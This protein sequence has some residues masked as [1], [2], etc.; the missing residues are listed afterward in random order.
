MITFNVLP[1]D[2]RTLL[3]R[4]SEPVDATALSIENYS[5]G[6]TSNLSTTLAPVIVSVTPEGNTG[7]DYSLSFDLPL[8]FL[9]TY[10][11]SVQDVFGED[12]SADGTENFTSS[13]PDYPRPIRAYVSG[14]NL[15]D[16]EFDR[17]VGAFNTFVA[18]NLFDKNV[19]PPQFPPS[20]LSY[21]T[22]DPS[23]CPS[24][25]IRFTVTSAPTTDAYFIRISGVRDASFNQ[26]KTND[27]PLDL[28]FRQDTP[29]NFARFGTLQV[30]ES[31]VNW[32]DP[33]RERT[34]ISVF[35]NAPIDPDDA[36]TSNFEVVR[37]GSHITADIYNDISYF[38]VI[39]Q[40]TI[41]DATG[42]L[43]NAF[44]EHA[45]YRDIHAGNPRRNV[46]ESDLIQLTN[47]VIECYK[48]H[49]SNGVPHDGNLDFN[50]LAAI[51]DVRPIKT[52]DECASVLTIILDSYIA[53]AIFGGHL[54]DDIYFV[55]FPSYP[56]SFDSCVYTAEIL[57]I[58]LR[59]HVGSPFLHEFPDSSDIVPGTM[60]RDSINA[61][62]VPDV[63]TASI[64][65][66][67]LVEKFQKHIKDSEFHIFPDDVNKFFEDIQ[68]DATYDEV[69]NED[70]SRFALYFDQLFIL[71][72]RHLA[73]AY[74]IGSYSVTSLVDPIGHGSYSNLYTLV[75]PGA[76]QAPIDITASV[77]SLGGASSTDGT[78]GNYLL[79]P[80]LHPPI[81]LESY[82]HPKN[83]FL[84]RASH[85]F[86][87]DVA[88]F[89]D[90]F[91][92][93]RPISSLQNLTVFITDLVENYNLH[94]L[95]ASHKTSDLVNQVVPL[96]LPKGDLGSLISS[97]NVLRQKFISHV[98]S[99]VYHYG[100]TFPA[101][102]PPVSTDL[103]SALTLAEA[104]GRA[105]SEHNSSLASHTSVFPLLVLASPVDG[106]TFP[107][108]GVKDGGTYRVDQYGFVG[109]SG[110]PVL[111][112]ATSIGGMDYD[113]GSPKIIPDA[114]QLN[115]S[116]PMNQGIV[117]E[118]TF[119][120][121]I[122]PRKISWVSDRSLSVQVD[123]LGSGTYSV[124]VESVTD[125]FGN[126]IDPDPQ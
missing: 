104:L 3:V 107:V 76:T 64:S 60:L 99:S 118:I 15:V 19:P 63:M 22:Y 17:E 89:P 106:Y 1:Q 54:N 47:V 113:T 86:S 39:D 34:S 23:S 73:G 29:H 77:D 103:D 112:S 18:A 5:L 65:L 27:V 7:K 69:V 124:T 50:Q 68:Y 74:D 62:S 92:P 79:L 105:Y 37:A 72:N 41:N 25:V 91:E 55:P 119:S 83:G 75:V 94:I 21:I 90:I 43:S 14:L 87:P 78:T 109:I 20:S 81:S 101:S 97:V 28:L 16:V 12:N 122:V 114:I 8:T 126:P 80:S 95:Q 102:L 108:N 57:Y 85:I 120:D 70:F 33:L 100:V 44:I 58:S 30:I 13:V 61:Y 117:P 36:I 111:A 40:T 53:H 116:R 9:G 6:V 84:T 59:M 35:F 98:G 26:S 88:K 2:E 56:D 45:Q 52:I 123:N 46:R 11:L 125:T 71:Y 110:R 31:F 38:P 93:P 66:F 10:S 24:T 82:Y 121:G 48:R 67:E 51:K 115:F 96:D 32:V 42:A 4:Y 49:L